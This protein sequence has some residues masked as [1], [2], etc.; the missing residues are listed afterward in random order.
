MP[1]RPR[2]RPRP[3]RVGRSRA[4][5]TLVELLVAVLV[6]AVGLAA[7][8]RG[9]GQ[10]LA[11]MADAR[12]EGDAAWRAARR[13]ELLRAVR[14]PHRIDGD[15]ADARFTERW[16]VVP[17]ADSAATELTVTIATAGPA[18]ARRRPRV[19]ATVAPC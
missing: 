16:T 11:A 4:G 15:S 17:R 8:A 3:R 19:Y 9:A 10:A 2:H 13:L 6:L 7:L 12:S 5:F 14:C 18:G 1:P